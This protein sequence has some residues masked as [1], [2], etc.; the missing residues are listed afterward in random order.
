MGRTGGRSSFVTG[1][2][3]WTR[4]PRF[5]PVTRNLPPGRASILSKRWRLPR[6]AL[7]P[8]VSWLKSYGA[9]AMVSEP[10]LRFYQFSHTPYEPE[11][12]ALVQSWCIG[13]DRNPPQAE[14]LPITGFVIYLE[15]NPMALVFMF[16]D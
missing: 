11:D 14:H 13:H 10:E 4:V 5:L 8:F 16:L 12:Y 9:T 2:T 6:I 3:S 15:Q 1:M 7:S